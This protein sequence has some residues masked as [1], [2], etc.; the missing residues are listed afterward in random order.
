MILKNK[1]NNELEGICLVTSHPRSTMPYGVADY[2]VSWDISIV[3]S[4]L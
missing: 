4:G 1:E 3:T 2:T